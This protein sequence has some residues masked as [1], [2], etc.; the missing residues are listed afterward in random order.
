MLLFSLGT[1]M[2]QKPYFDTLTP[3]QEKVTVNEGESKA[4][5]FTAKDYEGDPISYEFTISGTV[6]KSG[7][8]NN[9]TY[10]FKAGHIPSEGY[11]RKGS[12]YL[13]YIN[14]TDGTG[15][16]SY[17]WTITVINQ[18]RPPVP[19]LDAPKEGAIYPIGTS[20][21]FSAKSSTD[22][23]T[24]DQLS[25][26]WTFGDGDS[27]VLKEVYH[28]YSAP[29]YY[30][31]TLEVSDGTV[32]LTRNVNI[33][34]I[35]PA[36]KVMPMEISPLKPKEGKDVIFKASVK[37]TGN[38]PVTNVKVLFY[39]DSNT[40]DSKIGEATIYSINAS[41]TITVNKSW[42]AMDGPHTIYFVVIKEKTFLIDGPA[43]TTTAFTVERKA[44]PPAPITNYI[45]TVIIIVVIVSAILLRFLI[46][47][48][49][50]MKLK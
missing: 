42:K 47:I 6:V 49:I 12:P 27:L 35:A 2:A 45:Y 24:D 8:A 9:G 32:A 25:C 33:T 18:N 29:G 39:I 13:L 40:G 41:E 30:P 23:D 34:I 19:A 17:M 10:Q 16:M 36:L 20:I 5:S 22:P 11:D 43:E 37:N 50:R 21:A 46:K 4:F 7:T 31:I 48:W 1:T 28:S 38:A 14:I 44:D 26:K 3:D 15:D